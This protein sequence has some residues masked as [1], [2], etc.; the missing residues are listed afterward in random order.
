MCQFVV[1]CKS[2]IGKLNSRPAGRDYWRSYSPLLTRL[3]TVNPAFLASD[4]ERGFNLVGELNWEMSLRTGRLQRG[5][6]ET[7][8]AL[9]GRRSVNLPPQI[10]Q[11]FWP[12]QTSYS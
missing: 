11:P 3:R 12:S 9:T 4:T 6:S 7:G 10:L 8:G 1:A 5:H 2:H